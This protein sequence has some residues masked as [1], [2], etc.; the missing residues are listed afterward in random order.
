MDLDSK[1]LKYFVFIGMGI[2][3][4]YKGLKGLLIGEITLGSRSGGTFSPILYP[5]SIS[6]SLLLLI[7]GLIFTFL[8]VRGL[9]KL[10]INRK[11]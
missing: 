4:S 8:G 10:L 6:I 1:Y 7:P 11:K 5:D 3:H 9:I 2:Y